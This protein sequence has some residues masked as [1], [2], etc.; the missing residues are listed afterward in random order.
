MF[1]PG[2]RVDFTHPSRGTISGTIKS[3]NKRTVTLV[4][5]SDGSRGWRVT[6]QQLRPVGSAPAVVQYPTVAFSPGDT[7]EVAIP[8][9]WTKSPTLIGVVTQFTPGRI[10]VYALGHALIDDGSRLSAHTRRPYAEVLAEVRSVYNGLSPENLF[11]DGERSRSQAQKLAA[12]Y[13]RALRALFVEAGRRISE[14]EAYG[15]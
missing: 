11:A 4:D 2:D 7:V 8:N 10:E 5:T 6:P 3:V 9:P 14:E 15:P 13:N 1:K 12:V